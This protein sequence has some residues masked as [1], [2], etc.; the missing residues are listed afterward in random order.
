MSQ[1]SINLEKTVHALCTAD[2]ELV[3]VLASIGFTEIVKPIMLTTVGK[4]MTIPKG[5]AMRGLHLERIILALEEHGY[6]IENNPQE[7]KKS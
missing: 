7:D 2:P 5:A 3:P 6:L 1:K 4:V